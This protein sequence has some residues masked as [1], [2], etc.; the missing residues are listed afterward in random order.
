MGKK[1]CIYGP[2]LSE[3]EAE[4][5]AIAKE[6]M[7]SMKS[8]KSP[9]EADKSDGPDTSKSELEHFKPSKA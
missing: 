3:H 4:G 7:K 1:S 6:G 8:L 2:D 9:S 5:A